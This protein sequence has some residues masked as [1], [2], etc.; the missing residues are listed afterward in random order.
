MRGVFIVGSVLVTA[1]GTQLFI[2]TDHTETLFAWTIKPPVT[3]AFLGAFYFTALALAASSATRR[4]WA[5]AR[6]GVPGVFVFITLTVVATLLHL[7]KF[8]FH[9]DQTSAVSAA[10]LWLVI[11]V[12]D[13]PA[14]LLLWILQV[15]RPGGDPPRRA[16]LPPLYRAVAWAQAAVALAVGVSL[17]VVPS[18]AARLWPWTLTPLTAR[19]VAAWL[20]GLGLVLAA[21]PIENDWSRL[22][23]ATAAY[24]VLGILQTVALLRYPDDVAWGSPQAWAYLV[25]LGSVFVVGTYGWFAARRVARMSPVPAG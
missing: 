24:A 20:I 6:V 15:R 1:A 21:A 9:V 23:P 16:K 14:V 18:T 11:Y 8:H 19:A 10:W 13:P 4:T 25:F 5:E 7:G 22:H 3:A 12:L 17:F 2:L